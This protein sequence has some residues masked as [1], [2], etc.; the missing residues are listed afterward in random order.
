MAVTDS[1][2][3]LFHLSDKHGQMTRPVGTAGRAELMNAVFF[4]IDA[5]EQPLWAASRHGF[6]LPEDLRRKEEL[7]PALHYACSNALRTL[8][9][10]LGDREFIL[11][12]DFT[13]ADIIIGHC[14]AWSKGYD[15]P[16]PEGAVADYF[17]RLRERPAFKAM[18]KLREG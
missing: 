3:I 5:L 7:T 16:Q 13:I 10:M 15:F 1:T 17:A 18:M 2:A 14:G 9:A 4:A 6:I 11:G 12:D 8:E